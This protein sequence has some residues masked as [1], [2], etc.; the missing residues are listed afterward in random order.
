VYLWRPCY[1]GEGLAG[2][3]AGTAADGR[4]ASAW[5]KELAVVAATNRPPNNAN[6]WSARQ[7]AKEVGLSFMTASAGDLQH[8]PGVRRQAG[9]HRRALSGPPERALVLCLDEESQI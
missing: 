4:A 5:R 2:S 9:R 1:Q 3:R 8:R 7:L 6:H